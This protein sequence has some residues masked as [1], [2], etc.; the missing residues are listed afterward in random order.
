MKYFKN[1][2]HKIK[3]FTDAE[4]AD[5]LY[6]LN[7]ISKT[8]ENGTFTIEDEFEDVHSKLEFELIKI[9]GSTGKKIHTARSR[10]DQVLVA[11]H[12]YYKENLLVVKDKTK[13]FSL[14]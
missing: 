2:L 9:I 6:G 1:G 4:L 5:I 10:N 14:H 3:I 11:L 7:E 8:I 13:T 12:L